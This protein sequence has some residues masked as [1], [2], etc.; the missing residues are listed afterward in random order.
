MEKKL[1]LKESVVRG[2]YL[3]LV[4][5]VVI[6]STLLVKTMKEEK[7]TSEEQDYEYVSETPIV[8]EEVPVINEVN[9]MLKPY[10]NDNVKIGKSF[11]DY[12]AE[13]TQQENSITYYD[14]KY[15][16]N[17]GIDYT[18][19]EIF[20]V[21]SVLDGT[22]TDI[23]QD[24]LLGN[25]VEIKHENNFITTYQS[26]SDVQV[27]KGDMVTQGQV[28]GKSGTNKIDKDMGNHLHFEVYVNGQVVDPNIY[29]DKEIKKEQ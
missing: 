4:L 18:L 22:V 15:I 23:K 12:K 7:T 11:Y 3:I 8:N 25:V 28:I 19:D 21:V 1:K 9:K 16:Q 2:L 29:V 5:T 24:E 17:S 13:S 6:G 27:K 20:D 14:G 26:L 10:I